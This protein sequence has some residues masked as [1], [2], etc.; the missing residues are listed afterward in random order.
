MNWGHKA[1]QASALP[2][3]LKSHND[4]AKNRYILQG[5]TVKL[6]S[7]WYDYD[8]KSEAKVHVGAKKITKFLLAIAAGL[9][10]LFWLLVV[11]VESYDASARD[12]VLAL[13][14]VNAESSIPTW[15]AQT[16]LLIVAFLFALIAVHSKV[17]RA[18]WFGLSIIFL[19][20][21]IDEGAA[22]HELASAPVRELLGAHSGPL[23]YGWT[24]LFAAVGIVI[25]GLYFRFLLGLPRRSR[26]LFLLSA[27][28]F[29]GG[30]MGVEMV[31]AYMAAQSGE[32]GL[33]YAFAV[34]LEE[35]LEMT[36]AILCMY[37]LLD[38]LSEHVKTTELH[39]QP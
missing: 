34:G 7:A 22:I 39:F 27:I 13:F 10:G 5:K 8:M 23:Y 17:Q 32:V 38:Y 26:N 4:K 11:L 29:V 14:N 2:T 19:Y 12:S 25:A 36:G 20:I 21:S 28:V 30:G 3:E 18:Y 6:K 9:V 33:G 35:L 31:G 1:L 24:V 15:Y 37:T 16:V